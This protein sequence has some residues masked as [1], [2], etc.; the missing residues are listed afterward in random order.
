MEARE[1]KP[2]HTRGVGERPPQG[3]ADRTVPQVGARELVVPP[4]RGGRLVADHVRGVGCDAQLAMRQGVLTEILGDFTLGS[5][6]RP[7]PTG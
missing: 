1:G 7:L 6:G 5:R 2:P 4:G 3:D